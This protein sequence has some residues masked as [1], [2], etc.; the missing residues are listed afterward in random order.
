[1]I[2]ELLTAAGLMSGESYKISFVSEPFCRCSQ[3]NLTTKML[4]DAVKAIKDLNAIHEGMQVLEKHERVRAVTFEL[5]QSGYGIDRTRPL[6][7]LIEFEMRRYVSGYTAFIQH[8][9]H[10]SQRQTLATLTIEKK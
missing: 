10:N 1:M 7:A 5:Y 9:S 4:A 2:D 8:E 3:G 6:C